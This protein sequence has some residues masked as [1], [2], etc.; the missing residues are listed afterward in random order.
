MNILE[1]DDKYIISYYQ[2]YTLPDNIETHVW[3]DVQD[4][5]CPGEVPGHAGDQAGANDGYCARVA[6]PAPGS[7]AA[8]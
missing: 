7:S 2:I 5:L 4:V 3:S 6:R 1:G 8:A